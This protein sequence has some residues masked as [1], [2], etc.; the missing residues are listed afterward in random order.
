MEI[1]YRPSDASLRR[2]KQAESLR[3]RGVGDLQE[4]GFGRHWLHLLCELA[5]DELDQR[6]YGGKY[7]AV[8]FVVIYHE[9]KPFF[10]A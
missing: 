1:K 8:D 4:K 7:A 10:H 2:M 6:V 9:P 3:M 5:F